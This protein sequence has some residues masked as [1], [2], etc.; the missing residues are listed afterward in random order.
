MTRGCSYKQSRLVSFHTGDVWNDSSILK[1]CIFNRIPLS[2]P[3]KRKV[4]QSAEITSRGSTDPSHTISLACQD[5]WCYTC[6][7]GRR[8][9]SRLHGESLC[10]EPCRPPGS[11]ENGWRASGNARCVLAQTATQCQVRA[12]SVFPG[13]PPGCG[14]EGKKGLL[15]LESCQQPVIINGVYVVSTHNGIF[16]QPLKEGK[17]CR[18]LQ[19]RWQQ[20]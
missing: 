1:P 8:E 7:R 4:P 20:L 14:T 16:I 15:C 10:R 9:A 18:M 6:T 19:L 12:S 3:R 17:S 13:R 2:V 5:W 11:P